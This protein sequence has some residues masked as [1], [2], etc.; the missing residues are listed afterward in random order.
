MGRGAAIPHKGSF[1]SPNQV[2]WMA[3]AGGWGQRQSPRLTLTLG[4][5]APSEGHRQGAQIL[6]PGPASSICLC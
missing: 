6:D 5:T 4:V 1:F 3:G 2:L